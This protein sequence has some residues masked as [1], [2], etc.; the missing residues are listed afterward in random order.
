MLDQFGETVG[1]QVP[2]HPQ[3][4]VEVIETPDAAERVTQDQ[5]GPPIADDLE[6]SGDRARELVI[7]SGVKRFC[8]RIGDD[9]Q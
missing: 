6:R 1:Q 3:I 8:R 5:D 7:A 2:G 9:L 4:A